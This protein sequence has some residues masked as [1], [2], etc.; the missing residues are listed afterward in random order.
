MQGAISKTVKVIHVQGAKD[1]NGTAL[2]AEWI[3]LKN[4]EKVRW[5]ISCGVLNA[6]SSAAVTL[7]QATSDGGTPASLSLDTYDSI[8]GETVTATAV[9]SD[10]FNIVTGHSNTTIVIEAKASD[11]NVT[12][13]YD[14]VT[15]NIASPGGYSTLYSVTAEVSNLKYGSGA[16]VLA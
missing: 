4:A 8:S 15:L 11:L 1:M 14:W 13:G 9:T 6:N 7:T 10:T 3:N 2:T 16:T 12:D 5:I